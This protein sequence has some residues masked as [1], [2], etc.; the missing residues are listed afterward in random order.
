VGG[1]EII[2]AA[3]AQAL[4][5]QLGDAPDA[6]MT[7]IASIQFFGETTGGV[8][9][10]VAPW[11]WPVTV[12]QGD[13]L[14]VCISGSA[15]ACTPCQDGRACFVDCGPACMPMTAMDVCAPTESCISGFCSDLCTVDTDCTT[16]GGR[17]LGGRCVR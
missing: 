5:A 10:D 2:P 1:L 9:I 16:R 6:V 14:A 4:D 7:V 17:C 15:A 8:D 11:T 12:C 13:C 3:Y